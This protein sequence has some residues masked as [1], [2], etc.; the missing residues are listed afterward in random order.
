MRY[1]GL[2]PRTST[3]A[4]KSWTYIEAET[5]DTVRWLKVRLAAL[6]TRS[7]LSLN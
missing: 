4:N 5:D 7:S 2:M 1:L 3:A 6:C